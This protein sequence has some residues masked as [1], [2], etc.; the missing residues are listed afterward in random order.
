MS[1]PWLI[2]VSP[3]MREYREYL[4]K[5]LVT[6]YEIHIVDDHAPTWESNYASESTVVATLTSE[7]IVDAAL[8]ASLKHPIA[9]V[10]TWH[11]ERVIQAAHAAT[12]L[13]LP[14]TSP[15]AMAV[16]R[17][18]YAT[19]SRHEIADLQPR[20]TL[21]STVE[22][23]VTAARRLGY[24]VVLKPRDAG[25]SQGVVR[26]A[27]DDE[28][29]REFTATQDV[30][31]TDV[32]EQRYS[33][34]NTGR[35]VVEEFV[36]GPE[37]SV[38]AMVANGSVTPVYVARKEVGYPP[39]FEETGHLVEFADPLLSDPALCAAVQ[40]VHD[41]LNFTWGWTH[42]EWKLSS[43]GPVLIELNAR[44]GGDL[45]PYLGNLASGLSAGLLAG[46]VATGQ[47]QALS[48]FRSD[49]A[50]ARFAYPPSKD[51]TVADLSFDRAALPPEIDRAEL[52][53]E[54]GA[55]ISPPA[56]GLID[57]RVALV[58]AR[59]ATTQA[60]SYA[61]DGGLSVLRVNYR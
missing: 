21:C 37:V 43:R 7:A 26:V 61:L 60:C 33:F 22:E 6:A 55:V 28:V 29:E 14:T 13:G 59:A 1:R 39:Y 47:P 57:G 18:K 8:N 25:G 12:A 31:V 17:D 40:R 16:C 42:S 10:L 32:A 27:S 46:S 35:V 52:L 34:G 51:L 45:I 56:R 9:G 30:A 5:D 23:A 41:A 48:P 15:Q 58:T 3:G 20:A 24:P 2:V 36:D 38:D 19:R 4:L 49:V 11:E 54:P 53:V 44:L 50:G